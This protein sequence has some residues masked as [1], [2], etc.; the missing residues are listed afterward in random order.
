MKR[1]IAAMLFLVLCL[2]LAGCGGEKTEETKQ[3]EERGPAVVATVVASGSFVTDGTQLGVLQ[4]ASNQGTLVLR[5]ILVTSETGEHN[6]P[7]IDQLAQNGYN[8]VNPCTEYSLGEKIG[9]Y[10]DS[11][12]TEVHMSIFAVKNQDMPDES[13]LTEEGLKKLCEDKN[14]P[15]VLD[16]LPQVDDYGFL[17]SL[18]VDGGEP[19][20]YDVFFVGNQTCYMMQLSIVAGK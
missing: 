19:G 5:G 18:S 4:K 16:A 10:V 20:L 13:D 6:Y 2:S 14:Y 17:G 12:Y 3:T 11:D 9:F 7:A 1:T 15:M 8:Q